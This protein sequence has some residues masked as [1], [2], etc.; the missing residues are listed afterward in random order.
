ML[1]WDDLK[2]YGSL[3][4]ATGDNIHYDNLVSPRYYYTNTSKLASKLAGSLKLRLITEGEILSP[5]AQAMGLAEL[6]VAGCYGYLPN[7]KAGY[8]LS[9]YNV[10]LYL[11]TNNARCLVSFLTIPTYRYEP[12]LLELFNTYLLTLDC[13]KNT[14][15]NKLYLITEEQLMEL[16]T[17]G[18]SQ[19]LDTLPDG[20]LDK[21]TLGIDTNYQYGYTLVQWLDSF[22]NELD[23]KLYQGSHWLTKPNE[24]TEFYEPNLPLV[25]GFITAKGFKPAYH[26]SE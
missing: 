4:L 10:K 16:P 7:M 3:T 5:I 14:R 1:T 11:T 23:I 9:D 21:T 26:I 17:I 22:G 24:D 20:S 13:L 8:V 19:L 6:W 18:I 12:S 2:K 25:K 15:P